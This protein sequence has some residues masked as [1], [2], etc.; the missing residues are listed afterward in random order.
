[1]LYNLINN[2]S[3]TII[4]GQFVFSPSVNKRLE[5]RVNTVSQLAKSIITIILIVVGFF[6]SLAAIG[7]NITPF[8]AGAGIIGLALS[9]AS[10]SFIKDALNGFLIILEDQY[11]VGDII[12]LDEV[13]G[14]VENINLRITQLRDAEGRLITVPNSEI[15][16]VANL[17]SQWSRADINIPLNYDVNLEQALEVIANTATDIGKDSQWQ[18]F[19]LE[20]PQILGVEKFSDRAIIIRVW[21]KTEP[22]KQWDV[23]REFRRRLQIAFTNA[24]IPLTA[25]QQIWIHQETKSTDSIA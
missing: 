11:A 4:K 6:F 19:I 14:M 10:Q 23:S 25:P 2:L 15:R 5:L 24:G 9:F 18:Q 16:I 12:S 21:I 1:M 20:S 8:L 17:S 22:L 3:S 13:S 7:V